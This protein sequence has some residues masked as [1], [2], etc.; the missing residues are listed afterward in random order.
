MSDKEEKP[1]IENPLLAER[2]SEEDFWAYKERMKLMNK[3]LRKRLRGTIVWNPK[4]QGTYI[5][6]KPNEKCY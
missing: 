2:Q 1:A 4:E 3:L 5:R 6:I